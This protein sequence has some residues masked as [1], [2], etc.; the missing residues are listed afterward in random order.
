MGK[1]QS[2]IAFV[3]M[4]DPYPDTDDEP[5]PLL[6]QLLAAS[7]AHSGFD[8]VWLLC[9]GGIFLERARDLEREAGDEGIGAR[10]YFFDFPL[11]DV[12]DYAEIWQQLGKS[13][14]L[15]REQAGSIPRDW[16]FLLDSGTPQMKTTLFLA[17]RSGLFPARLIQGIPPRFAGG[18]YKSREVRVDGIPE[19]ELR[20]G[21][22]LWPDRRADERQAGQTLDQVAR[23]SLSQPAG[24]ISDQPVAESGLFEEALRVAMAAARYD[25]P[26]LI[27]GETGTGKT[28]VARRVHEASARKGGPFVEVNCSAIP[29][30]LAESELFGHVR[31]AFS[32]A[33]TQRSGK[34]RAAQGGTLFLDE[35][36]DLSPELQAKLLK[37]IDDKAVTP[38]G[39]DEPVEADARLVAATNRDL[40]E[41][42][43]NGEFR[44]DL[45]ERLQVLR[46]RLP[47]LRERRQD[48]RPLVGRFMALWNAQYGER[49][50]VTEESL[51]LLESYSWPGN[52]RGLQNA[53][54]SAACSSTSDALGPESF[55]EDIR[56]ALP[57]GAVSQPGRS[58]LAPASFLIDLPPEGINLKARLLQIEWEYV[59]LALRRAGGRREA[60]ASLLGMTGHAFRKA[61]KERL[62]AFADEGWEEGL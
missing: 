34:F 59:S 21:K 7:R 42:V 44:R 20:A 31:G 9:T 17:A 4:K 23:R 3:G 56:H 58:L 26:L 18:A 48:I 14:A 13:L 47:P 8:E 49:R 5:G 61:L 29:E 43:K 25:D 33:S 6:A 22:T 50:Y 35:V 53:L 37:A 32:G 36:G 16:T 39:S 12:I 51:E 38:V 11:R 54:R 19:I 46:L 1:I 27:L 41:M 30:S 2:L 62:S 28:M 55:S 45:Y 52:V 15:I 60:A 40:Q 24:R 57:E 10:F